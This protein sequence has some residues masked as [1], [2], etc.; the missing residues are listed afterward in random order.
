MLRDVDAYV[1]GEQ[2][3]QADIV[4]L[5]TNENPY[6]PSPKVLE[7]IRNLDSDAMV[8][9]PNAVSLPLRQAVAERYELPGPEWVFAG[10]GMDEILAMTIRTFVDPGETVISVTPTYSLYDV[11]VRLH[12]AKYKEHALT[13]DSQLPEELYTAQG[14][15]CFVP[16]PHAPTGILFPREDLE[17]L[18]SSFDGIVFIDEAYVDF[19]EDS[20][21]DF[22]QR[23]DNVIVGRTFSKSFSL[24]GL[25][26]GLAMAN[27]DLIAGFMKT[28]DSYNLNAVSQ[29]AALAA[30]NDY[31]TM[32]THAEKI[33]T[34]RG[35]MTDGLR[36][37]GFDVPDSHCNFVL[38][39]R[40]GIP[41]AKNIMEMLR[42]NNILVR[43]FEL[44]GLE[45]S[46]R[47][48]V[49]TDEEIDRLFTALQDILAG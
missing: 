21:I 29:V 13:E 40:H 11:L 34:T 36:E 30:M 14:K 25:R 20:C 9:Y 24:A 44:P 10:N 19:A 46:L 5:N 48:S 37:L 42:E 1:P 47:I 43:H 3:N 39:T 28:K 17:R 4:K 45:N 41:T 7:A 6:P 12:G 15:L 2:R 49:G 35:R 16:R 33:K 26:V 31:E 23:F 27:P 22:P 18:C 8:R 38:A 32:L